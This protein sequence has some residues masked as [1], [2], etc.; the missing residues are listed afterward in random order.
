M[1]NITQMVQNSWSLSKPHRYLVH[2][3]GAQNKR[4]LAKQGRIQPELALWMNCK[5]INIPG[6]SF[7]ELTHAYSGQYPID[8]PTSKNFSKLSAEFYLSENHYE[9]NFFLEWSQD[10]FNEGDVSFNFP[11]E[12][13]R[14]ITIYQLPNTSS[15]ISDAS[16]I[17]TIMDAYPKSIGDVMLS[18]A[19]VNSVGEFQVGFAFTRM[20]VMT[21]GAKVVHG[22]IMND[23][24]TWLPETPQITTGGG[25]GY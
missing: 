25:G 16:A 7:T 10:I 1:T 11:D 8:I 6:V 5:S 24:D 22:S 15:S 4:T 2:I 20:K 17:F 9:R 14:D 13:K 18:Y 23:I 21:Y 19:E 3:P 12:Y